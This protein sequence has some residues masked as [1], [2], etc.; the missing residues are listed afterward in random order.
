[1]VSSDKRKELAFT[2][3][4]NEGKMNLSFSTLPGETI[5]LAAG[6]DTS[7]FNIL[8]VKATIRENWSWGLKSKAAAKLK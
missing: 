7:K 8:P 2:V 1:M 4:E 6:Y 5:L 3:Y